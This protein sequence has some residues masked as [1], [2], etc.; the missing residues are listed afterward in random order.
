MRIVLSREAFLDAVGWTS[1]ILPAKPYTPVLGG[2]YIITDGGTTTFCGYDT[3]VS[4]EMELTPH[5]GYQDGE[6]LVSGRLLAAISKALPKQPT[7]E[8]YT[9]VDDATLFVLCGKAQFTLPMMPLKQYPKLPELPDDT[10][11]V[12]G[13]KLATAVAQVLPA[14]G[15]D[16]AVPALCSVYMVA[17][18]K[19]LTLYAT[20]KHRVAC[21]QVPWDPKH[22]LPGE[23]RLLVP[24]RALA[25]MAQLNADDVFLGFTDEA[26][27]ILGIH[28]GKRMATTRL[29]DGKFPNCKAIVPPM[30]TAAAVLDSAELLGALGRAL[31]VDGTE[32]PVVHL[33]LSTK[34]VRLRA[35][36]DGVGGIDDQIGVE[37]LGEPQQLSC[38][39][40]YLADAING[41]RSNK[42]L[43]GLQ[44]HNK[45]IVLA[46]FDV[47]P[48]QDEIQPGKYQAVKADYY[49]VVMPMATL[50]PL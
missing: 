32:F 16:Q 6:A 49:H 23:A 11:G 41:C 36:S 24:S 43:L 9:S 15:S 25:E 27:G 28:A 19:H 45:P 40:R 35:G 31:L 4:A 13:A 22:V 50:P 30:Y 33:Q 5:E 17:D 3:E 37:Y 8:L 47:L 34:G 10:G 2:V 44:G 20:D 46:P 14:A 21:S 39:T 42:V 7:V 38:N 18:N 12:D 29:I 1:R 26:S 48:L